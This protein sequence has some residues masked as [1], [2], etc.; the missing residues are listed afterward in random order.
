METILVYF[1][2]AYGE[3]LVERGNIGR[4]TSNLGIVEKCVLWIRGWTCMW[5]FII[6]FINVEA[7]VTVVLMKSAGTGGVLSL[8]GVGQE[9]LAYCMPSQ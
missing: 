2:L 8:D 9:L 5:E 7:W 3:I 4:R 6:E 1:I